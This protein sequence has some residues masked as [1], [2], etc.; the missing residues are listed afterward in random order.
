MEFENDGTSRLVDFL[1]FCTVA[2][3]SPGSSVTYSTPAVSTEPSAIL[4][5]SEPSVSLVPSEPPVSLVLSKSYVTLS[6]SKPYISLVPSEPS[7]SLSSSELSVSL[8]PSEPSVSLSSS[9]PSVSLV[10]NEPSLTLSSSKPYV[11]FVPSEPSVSL[12]SSEP[13]VSLVPSE[14]SVTLSSSEPSRS[15]VSLSA[16][17]STIDMALN[18]TT[19]SSFFT[20]SQLNH[21]PSAVIVNP[22]ESY[23]SD[24]ASIPIEVKSPTLDV[25]DVVVKSFVDLSQEEEM[26]RFPW[27]NVRD[28]NECDAAERQFKTY[29]SDV[30]LAPY[31]RIKRYQE[32]FYFYDNDFYYSTPN[33]MTEECITLIE[34]AKRNLNYFWAV[35]DSI[36][37]VTQ[38]HLVAM[39]NLTDL[40]SHFHI[41]TDKFD[42]RLEEACQLRES[43][44]CEFRNDANEILKYIREAR[45]FL[46]DAQKT[47]RDWQ[48]ILRNIG[49]NKLFP[50]EN[51]KQ[52]LTKNITKQELAK[53][54]LSIQNVTERERYFQ[55]IQNVDSLMQKYGSQISRIRSSLKLI[56]NFPNGV[57]G[58]KRVHQL[59]V[60]RKMMT[61]KILLPK[62][63][64]ELEWIEVPVNEL[65]HNFADFL[66][67]DIMEN[68]QL[69]ADE[70]IKQLNLNITDPLLDIRL[71]LKSIET[72]LREYNESIKMD[73]Q[74]YL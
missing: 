35:L 42:A 56:F 71:K 73:S 15:L 36:N 31:G 44:A 59:E 61:I 16:E 38:G 41:S 11:S 1:R 58:R 47:I 13:S 60:V 25:D 49:I 27:L 52:Y 34:R 9:Q 32:L 57:F 26:N 51:I 67:D 12:S 28:L 54:F 4:S 10:P 65:N 40:I 23:I 68:I 74:F 33:Y 53:Q 24:K 63:F 50:T 62:D 18:S 43:L 22:T 17:A 20:K 39:R 3:T 69:T 7:V 2:K 64:T 29:F 14:P 72:N 5:P 19:Q 6:S 55:S 66:S 21:S 30:I 45:T 70:K 37:N 48:G 8:V 46:S